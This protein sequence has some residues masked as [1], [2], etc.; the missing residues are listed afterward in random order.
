MS[1]MISST[2]P[3]DYDDEDEPVSTPNLHG[4]SGSASPLSHVTNGDN[5]VQKLRQVVAEVTHGRIPAPTKRR[6]GF[7]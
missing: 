7:F 4:N 5:A 2:P 3:G 1:T 6:P